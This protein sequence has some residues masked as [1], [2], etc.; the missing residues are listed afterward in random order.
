MSLGSFSWQQ[1]TARKVPCKRLS[2]GIRWEGKEGSRLHGMY[3]E[4]G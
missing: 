3:W 1:S 4:K 2:V